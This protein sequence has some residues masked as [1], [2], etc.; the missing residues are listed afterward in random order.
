M[1]KL[2]FGKRKEDHA[3]PLDGRELT[4]LINLRIER[5]KT[6]NCD[7]CADF[8]TQIHYRGMID[9]AKESE[10]NALKFLTAYTADYEPPEESRLS[11]FDQDE[12]F[13]FTSHGPILDALLEAERKW[14][15]EHDSK[16]VDSDE[17]WLKR[18][19]QIHSSE[20]ADLLAKKTGT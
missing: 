15:K 4:R 17:Y 13:E 9:R 16:C 8:L 20:K 10:N 11:D 12:R 3:L 18:C 5:L 6:C 7:H 19:D 14:R 2:V 1:F